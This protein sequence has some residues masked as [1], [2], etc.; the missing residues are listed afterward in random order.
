MN[1][2]T[3]SRIVYVNVESNDIV[4][5][6]KILIQGPTTGSAETVLN[7]IR[8]NNLLV[9]NVKRGE[10][11]FHSNTKVRHNDLVFRVRKTD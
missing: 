2:Y 7:E 3:K 8:V 10:A 5:G 11:T 6:D 9:E 1:Y 4:V